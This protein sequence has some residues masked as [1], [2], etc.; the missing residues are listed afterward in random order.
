MKGG[1]T[2]IAPV[3]SRARAAPCP[4][5]PALQE[6]FGQPTVPRPGGGVPGA[7]LLGLCHAGPGRL[8][9]LGVAPRLTPARAQGQTVHPALAPG[10]GLVADRGRS[11]DAP[12]ARRAHPGGPAVRRVGARQSVDFP[13]GR[14]CVTP[15]GRRTP[16][17][18]G[19]PRS[20]WL[21]TLGHP[22][23]LV[24]WLQPQP[25]P[26]WLARETLAA[27]PEA[28]VR[29]EVRD[30]LDTPGVRTRQITVVPTRLAPARYP[31]TDLAELSCQRWPIDTA[32]AHLKPAMRMDGRQCT[33]GPGVL[34]ARTILALV[35]NL[36][37]MVLGHAARRQRIN[38]ER[39]SC[40][41]ALRWLSAPGTGMPLAA[42]LSIPVR[43]QRVE[44]RVKKRRPKRFPWML[45]P[46]QE[47]PQQRLQHERGG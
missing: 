10:A 31:G 1:G 11:S 24:P 45:T 32:L 35:Y 17:V 18:Q 16:A 2:A 26:A 7:R 4:S 3:W 41:E 15:G 43:P 23:Q 13:P 8:L 29:R 19:V 12:L 27:L 25:C 39:R 44:P 9:Q 40:L 42:R 33:T 21:T 46:R 20:R 30:P 38:V 34:K 22:D 6:A 36:A 47:R 14:P 5:P 37:R 28:F